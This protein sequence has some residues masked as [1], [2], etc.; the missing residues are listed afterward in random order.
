MANAHEPAWQQVQQEAAVRV[1]AQIA[2]HVV[3]AAKGPFGVDRLKVYSVHIATLL[4]KM[5]LFA[6]SCTRAVDLNPFS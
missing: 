4:E 1:A 2:Q 5:Q 6:R 3:R